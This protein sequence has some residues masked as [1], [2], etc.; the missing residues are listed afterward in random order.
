MISVGE[1]DW[2]LFD[3]S[4]PLHE[5]KVCE[6]HCLRRHLC[7][8]YLSQLLRTVDSKYLLVIFLKS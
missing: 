2:L 5:H 1:N 3:G 6:E 7:K 8:Y 4:Y